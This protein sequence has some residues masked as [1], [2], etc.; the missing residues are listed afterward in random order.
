MTLAGILTGCTETV[1]HTPFEKVKIRLQAVEFSHFR[2]S[3]DCAYQILRQEGM[4]GF[5]QGFE[6][7]KE[8]RDESNLCDCCTLLVS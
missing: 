6:V 2:N 8:R 1:M 3:W 5:Y 7:R 4:L